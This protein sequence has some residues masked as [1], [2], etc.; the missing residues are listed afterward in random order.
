MHAYNP[1]SSHQARNIG[2]AHEYEVAAIEGRIVGNE[3]GLV[4]WIKI[5]GFE[6]GSNAT[7]KCIVA[8]FPGNGAEADVVNIVVLLR[9]HLVSIA[10]IRVKGHVQL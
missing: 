8:G 9:C 6:E 2:E 4:D 10:T 1:L 5:V 3:W 7:P